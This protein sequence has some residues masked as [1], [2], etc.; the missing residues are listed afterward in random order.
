MEITLGYR[1]QTGLPVARRMECGSMAAV[2]AV[3]TRRRGAQRFAYRLL[4]AATIR[5]CH[6]RDR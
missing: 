1:C 3:I 6:L 5:E 2:P 4:P